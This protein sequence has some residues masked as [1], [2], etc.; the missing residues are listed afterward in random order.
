MEKHT[1]QEPASQTHEHD[2]ETSI[3]TH[4][5]AGGEPAAVEASVVQ[6]E[7]VAEAQAGTRRTQGS[8]DQPTIDHGCKIVAHSE[9]TPYHKNNEDQTRL[10]KR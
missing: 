8:L 4:D 7:K 5:L 1:L 6:S 3:R 10:T 9:K 2:Q